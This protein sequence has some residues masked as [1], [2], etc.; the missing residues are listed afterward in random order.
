MQYKQWKIEY[1]QLDSEL[2]RWIR[3]MMQLPEDEF[4]DCLA[5]RGALLIHLRALRT[6]VHDAYGA[7]RLTE[8][9]YFQIKHRVRNMTKRLLET[10][11]KN[12]IT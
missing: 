10:N 7:N 2:G 6:Y 8:D 1:E 3:W 9:E 11:L 12:E 5:T 4:K